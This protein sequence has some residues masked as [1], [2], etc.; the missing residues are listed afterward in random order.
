MDTRSAV[1]L[2]ASRM[3]TYL[4]I[5]LMAKAANVTPALQITVM[6][7][8]YS[9]KVVCNVINVTQEMMP[10]VPI[11]QTSRPFAPSMRKMI[12]V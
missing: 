2:E 1:A 3:M 12:S 4:W 6:R 8:M 5:V 9:R 7:T 10:L 11:R